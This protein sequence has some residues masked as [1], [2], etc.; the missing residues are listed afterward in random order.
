MFISMRKNSK[1]LKFV[2]WIVVF[3][4]LATIVVVWGIGDRASGTNYVAKVGEHTITQSEYTNRYNAALKEMQA[5]GQTPERNSAFEKMV[6]NDLVTQHLLLQE[7]KALKL[8]V[9]DTEVAAVITSTP[10]FQTN[11]IFNT[12]QYQQV[13]ISNGYTPNK[14]EENIRKNLLLN[15]MVGLIIGSV[16]VSPDEMIKEFTYGYTEL[17]ASY[18]T[19]SADSYLTN[20]KPDDDMLQ[21]Y[22]DAN[23]E[24][25]RLAPSIKLKYIKFSPDNFEY[26]PNITDIDLQNRYTSDPSSFTTPESLDL[27]QLAILVPSWD[28][29]T[30][31]SHA[32]EIMTSVLN[33]LKS[34]TSFDAVAKKYSKDVIEN[35]IGTI[36]KPDDLNSN[37]ILQQIFALQSGQV[38]E[39][40]KSDYGVNIFKVDNHTMAYMQPFDEVKDVLRVSMEDE[41]KNKAYRDYVYS[42]SRAIVSAGNISAY[43]AQNPDKFTVVETDYIF[44]DDPN[45]FFQQDKQLKDMLF[46]LPKTEVSPMVERP[47]GTYI[48][49]LDDRIN[50]HIPALN[51]IKDKVVNDYL[52]SLA[53][54]S[55]LDAVNKDIP[56][57]I[58]N[59][60]DFNAVAKKFNTHTTT[61]P[62]FKRV[63]AQTQVAWADELINILFTSTTGTI[64]KY[65]EKSNNLIYV[66]HIDNMRL[67]LES[68]MTAHEDAIKNYLLSIK[69]K[70]A[71]SSALQELRNKY[72]VIVNPAFQ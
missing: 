39:I 11:G 66:V 20:T 25:Y 26:T 24:K 22:Y 43:L 17:S 48:Y 55:A 8:H 19:V 47:D 69:Q 13:L 70:E 15:K 67:P 10:A 45:A 7:A 35:K 34:G 30:E 46:S 71:L 60:S 29:Q 21:T 56:V 38:S 23:M 3:A 64:V 42:I 14:Y 51:E 2:L 16:A 5:A 72:K 36:T 44:E 12:Q 68:E 18:F 54:N 52:M 32:Y 63:D 59:Q 9:T 31:V 57:T 53:F 37:P 61:I 62:T 6:V 50:S 1:V 65:P 40:I 41:A 4:F 49:E 28:N 33:D 27:S 58:D